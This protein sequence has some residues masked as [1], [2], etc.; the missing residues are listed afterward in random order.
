MCH[1]IQYGDYV[2]YYAAMAYEADPTEIG[3]I[4]ELKDLLA[5]RM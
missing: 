5:A 4:A 1:A 3:P 2:S